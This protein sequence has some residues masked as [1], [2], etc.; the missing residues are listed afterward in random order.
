MK[1]EY[2]R[3]RSWELCHNAFRDVITYEDG[4]SDDKK[5]QLA[6]ELACYL[7]SFGM[8]RNSILLS[9][10]YLALVDVVSVIVDKENKCLLD[11]AGNNIDEIYNLKKDIYDKL[12]IVKDNTMSKRTVSDTL[13]SKILLGT[14]GCTV[15]Y[16]EV[17]RKRLKQL[18]PQNPTG[19][20]Q[21]SKGS[22]S[23][24][25]SIY[26]CL[27]IHEYF[28]KFDGLTPMRE[29]DIVLWFGGDEES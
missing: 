3:E 4:C 23:F 19:I 29:M 9:V 25:Y 17:V 6:V 15:A 26:D 10:N 8:Y 14:L 24:L 16:D 7:A 12:N 27:N 13:I 22:V 11:D 5:K 18:F 20:T 2:S 21:F 1:N 28:K